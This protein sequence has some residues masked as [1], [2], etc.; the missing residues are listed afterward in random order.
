MAPPG[1]GQALRESSQGSPEAIARPGGRAQEGRGRCGTRGQGAHSAGRAR[2]RAGVRGA[3]VF[4]S[5]GAQ[6]PGSSSTPSHA[7]PLRPGLPRLRPPPQDT[8][9]APAV[10]SQPFGDFR[11]AAGV[12]PS[13]RRRQTGR[14]MGAMPLPVGGGRESQGESAAWGR[15]YRVV[16]A[17]VCA[18]ACNCECAVHACAPMCANAA[19]QAC[20]GVC[21][22]ERVCVRAQAVGAR[23]PAEPAD[24][25]PQ[26]A[27]LT[28][29]AAG[30]EPARGRC[31]VTRSCWP[32]RSRS[33]EMPPGPG[34]ALTLPPKST[35]PSPWPS[36][37]HPRPP[38]GAFSPQGLASPHPGT[39][40]R[41]GLSCLFLQAG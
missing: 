2:P 22:R 21:Q 7:P 17:C 18:Y 32:N 16:Q 25:K 38:K 34:C 8:S 19:A 39:R 28:G 14:Q 1:G 6:R 10:S 24:R 3:W 15:S 27:A 41:G 35:P 12:S 20:A 29:G 13:S 26:E 40:R 37:P 11:S 31:T 36:R 4:P 23:S 9:C 30:P 33:S 5:P